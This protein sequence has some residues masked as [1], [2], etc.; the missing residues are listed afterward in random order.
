[1]AT[2]RPC[3]ISLVSMPRPESS[4]WAASMSETIS[5]P[6]AAP[7]AAVVSPRPNVT[8]AAEPGG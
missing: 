2:L 1:V 6:S 8:E 5:P 7:G 3:Q 4:P